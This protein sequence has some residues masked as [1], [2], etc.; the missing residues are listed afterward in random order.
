[1]TPNRRNLYGYLFSLATDKRIALDIRHQCIRVLGTS[2]LPAAL[3]VLL[4][5]CDG[6]RTLLGKAK[7]APK[8]PELLAALG[9]LAVGF[10]EDA[11]ATAVLARAAVSE[12]PEIRAAT[13]PAAG[14]SGGASG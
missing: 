9:A 3:D 5:L 10:G 7:L 6:G 11:R 13:D 14:R 8:S 1:M 12:D 4:G 2:R